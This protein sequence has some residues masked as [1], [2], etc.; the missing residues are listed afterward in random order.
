MKSGRRKG[1]GRKKKKPRREW[2]DRRA[3]RSAA[4]A[5]SSQAKGGGATAQSVEIG[6]KGKLIATQARA[7]KPL[8]EVTD[9]R[10]IIAVTPAAPHLRLVSRS[11]RLA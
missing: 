11:G 9:D 5:T 7:P 1:T 4:A 6:R 10:V 3:M 2:L 8:S